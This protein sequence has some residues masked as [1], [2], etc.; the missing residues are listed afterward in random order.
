MKWDYRYGPPPEM[1]SRR[2]CEN[3]YVDDT[4]D[5]DEGHWICNRKDCGTHLSYDQ[6][7]ALSDEDMA[8]FLTAYSHRAPEMEIEQF[9]I[10]NQTD[11]ARR[12]HRRRQ[13]NWHGA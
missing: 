4:G 9:L 8:E 2:N 5:D 6:I 10:S 13:A 12:F 7:R 11:H 1:C 3:P